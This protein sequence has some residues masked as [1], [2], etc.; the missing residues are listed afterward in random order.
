VAVKLALDDAPP[1]LF[2]GLRF[3]IA[4]SLSALCLR[5]R[6]K[7]RAS[8]IRGAPL[9][10]LL[11]LAYAAQTI[12]LVT[13][14]PARSGFITGLNVILIP[15]WGAWI[16][17]QRPGLFPLLGLLLV[18]PGMWL[19]TSP[20]TGS[21]VIGDSF[22]LVCAFLFALHVVMLTRLGRKYDVIGLLFAQLSVTAVLALVAS[23]VLE[24]PV[25]RWSGQLVIALALTGVLASFVTTFLQLRL[26][27]MVSSARTALIF[28][29]EPLFAALASGLVIG[30]RLGVKG[31]IGGGIIL[32]GMIVSEAKVLVP[33]RS[34]REPM[35]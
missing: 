14:T 31:W 26:Q 17:H 35:E 2:L 16:L 28:A 5:R 32:I 13:T 4:A 15:F 22:T 20:G 9:G 30:E 11:S 18:I 29:T 34:G 10:L 27:P 19:L 6:P 3:A 23:L 8:L 24:A 21:W 12:G 7:L 1:L 25:L 33:N